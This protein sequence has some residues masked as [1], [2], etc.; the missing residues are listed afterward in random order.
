MEKFEVLFS[1]GEGL[2]GG[3]VNFMLVNVGSIRLY[4]E[5]DLSEFSEEEYF[6]NQDEIDGMTF[7]QLK[8]E[9]I[10][11]AIENGIDS[12]ILEFVAA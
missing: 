12:Q 5:Y 10:K 11:Q 7:F 9:I 2:N 3:A 8:E 6:D 4:A 1:G